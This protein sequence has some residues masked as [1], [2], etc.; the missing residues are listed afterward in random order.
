[1]LLAL[2]GIAKNEY[3]THSLAVHIND[4]ECDR[5]I[6]NCFT[7]ILETRIVRLLRISVTVDL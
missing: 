2:A 5:D 3:S 4:C 7:D 6:I 1:M